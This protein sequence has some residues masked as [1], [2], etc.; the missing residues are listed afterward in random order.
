MHPVPSS[1]DDGSTL[2]WSGIVEDDEKRERKWSM[3]IHRKVAKDKTS[4]LS[5]KGFVD[6]QES[7]YEGSLF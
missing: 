6:R 2:D 4:P 5:R 3:G 1:A 7:V